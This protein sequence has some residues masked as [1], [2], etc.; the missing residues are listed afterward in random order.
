MISLNNETSFKG[1]LQQ[2]ANIGATAK[3][4]ET[5]TND[6]YNF[7]IISGSSNTIITTSEF[8]FKR[9]SSTKIEYVN[10][11]YAGIYTYYLTKMN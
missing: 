2:N 3:V 4:E 9:I 1:L 10:S 8:Q 6:T 7:K 11:P 5:S